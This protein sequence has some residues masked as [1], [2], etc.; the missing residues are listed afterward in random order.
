MKKSYVIASIIGLLFTGIYYYF[1]LP[2]LNPSSMEFWAF[3]IVV[4]AIF[5]IL[6]T[7]AYYGSEV[8]NLTRRKMHNQVSQFLQFQH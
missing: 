4:L 3:I 7:I 2:P 5:M 1:V 6:E 8:V